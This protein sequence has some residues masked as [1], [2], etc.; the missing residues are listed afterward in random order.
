MPSVKVPTQAALGVILIAGLLTLEH[1]GAGFTD[2]TA[3]TANAVGADTLN[4][5]TAVTA[6]GGASVTIDWTATT[7]TYATGHRVLSSTTPG[8][9]YSQVAQTTPRTI[10]THNDT[11][12]DGTY[13]YIVR[14]YYLTW[15]SVDSNEV[16]A[17]LTTPEDFDAVPPGSDNCPTTFNIDQYDTD[18]DGDGDICDPTPTLASS[19]MFTDTGQTLTTTNAKGLAGGDLDGDGDIDITYATNGANQIWFNDGTG[20]FTDSG[21]TLGATTSLGAATADLDGD[22]DIDITYAND[23]ANEIWFNDGTGTFTDSGQTLGASVSE[24]AALADFDGDGDID[25]TYANDGANEIWFN[26]GTGTFTDSG[27]TLGSSTTVG[28]A[29]GDI[30]GDG[31][32]DITYA[33]DGVANTVWT[34]DGTGTFTDTGQTLGSSASK[35]AAFG[36]IDNDGDLDVVYGNK[37]DAGRVWR[38]DGTGTFT[39]TGQTLGSTDTRG[40]GLGDLD[41]D[42]DIDIVYANNNDANSVWYNDGTGTFTDSGQTLGNYATHEVVVADLDADGDLDLAF[43]DNSDPNTVW[44]N[45]PEVDLVGSWQTGL[46]HTTGAGT[47]RLL[48]FVGGNE[49]QAASTPTLTSVTYGNQALTLIV[50]NQVTSTFTAAVEIWVLDEAGITAATDSTFI[51]TWS[52]PP[53]TPL[54][55]HA[56][57]DNVDQAVP[58]GASAAAS[59]TA[60]VPNPVPISPVATSNGDMVLATAAAGETGTYAPQNGFLVGTNEE[61]TVGGTFALGTGYTPADGS[62]ETALMLFNP[63]NPPW[64]NRQVVVALVLNAAP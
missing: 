13:Y 52:S 61:T 46:T 48:V 8:G 50:S 47:D 44:I 58:T 39:D 15:E 14:S 4:P 38:N 3:N 10:T 25:I 55:S 24:W 1:A 27:Q 34:N 12:A 41:G 18:G 20:T 17:T 51:P 57:F 21:Q 54:Y 56:T 28:A 36:D 9:P 59:S 33:N 62:A 11:P 45:A 35:A 40:T 7:D 6:A 23:G 63:T 64:I 53:D 49:E 37:T 2:S 19:G 43:A 42:G 32:I 30:D 5:P 29:V 31:D 16:T 22:G 60:D 26:D